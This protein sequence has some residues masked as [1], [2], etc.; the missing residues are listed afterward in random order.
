M[1]DI[2]NHINYVRREHLRLSMRSSRKDNYISMITSILPL[3]QKEERGL[4]LMY[5]NGNRSALDAICE[6]YL[7]I[8]YSI[9][10]KYCEL[11]P[12][13]DVQDLVGEGVLALCESIPKYTKHELFNGGPRLI[14][15]AYSQISKCIRKSALNRTIKLPGFLTYYSVRTMERACDKYEC[16]YGIRMS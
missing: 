14:T 9:A 16:K 4:F 2:I 6:S 10:N 15:Y 12:N 5:K 1:N 7:P 11:Y 8:I 13:N 3:S